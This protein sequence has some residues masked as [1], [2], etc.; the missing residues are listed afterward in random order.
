MSNNIECYIEQLTSTINSYANEVN[1]L[2]CELTAFR[3]TYL[4][5]NTN[6]VSAT[7]TSTMIYATLAPL[8][9]N[10]FEVKT[11]GDVL[12]DEVNISTPEK[13][14]L[15]YYQCTTGSYTRC[16]RLGKIV[17]LS[18]N[19]NVTTSTSN[20][21]YITGLPPALEGGW[22]GSSGMPAA[23]VIRWQITADGTL[24]SDGAPTTGWHNGNIV[25]ICQ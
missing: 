7:N 22:A 15:T 23:G 5:S 25:Y 12:I 17:I 1:N 19:I 9:R 4:N 18:F 14:T 2:K 6:I 11:N 21:D 8:E 16:Y 13:I 3:N 20:Y 10:V 24:R